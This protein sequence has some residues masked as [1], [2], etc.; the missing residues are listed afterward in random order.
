MHRHMHIARSN[1]FDVATE[2]LVVVATAVRRV[3]TDLFLRDPGALR[4]R[5]DPR[6]SPLLN[7]VELRVS[8]YFHRIVSLKCNPNLTS[9]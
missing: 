8:A 3:R 6:E 1:L 9:I 2:D 4:E 5:R 7:L